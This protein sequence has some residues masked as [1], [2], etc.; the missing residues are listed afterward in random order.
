M[1]IRTISIDVYEDV[2]KA[3]GGDVQGHLVPASYMAMWGQ[4]PRR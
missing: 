1:S 3:H 4:S 2:V